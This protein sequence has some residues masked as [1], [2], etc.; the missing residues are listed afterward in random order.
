MWAASEAADAA[1][2]KASEGVGAVY[3]Q[4]EQFQEFCGCVDVDDE[5]ELDLD[6]VPIIEI[7]EGEFVYGSTR[8]PTTI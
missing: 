2:A 6:S 4:G 7:S 3:D 5:V 8:I 1:W